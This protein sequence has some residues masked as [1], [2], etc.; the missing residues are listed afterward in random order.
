MYNLVKK[1]MCGAL[2]G[3]VIVVGTPD[4]GT[5]L[6]AH[7]WI[8]QS[9]RAE[10]GEWIKS[11]NGKWW[12][13]RSDG[14]YPK[15][16]WEKL[17]NKW[18]YFDSSGWMQTGW[19]KIN[20]QWYY[21]GDAGDGS[22]KTGWRKINNKW[23]YLGSA[24]DGA[25]KYGWQ[26]INN[27][28][29][30]LGGAEDGVMKFG[31]QNINSKWYYFGN[32]EDGA[33]KTG[34]VNDSNKFYYLEDSGI[35]AT[36][37][38]Y[39][40]G[41]W[42]YLN[43]P[44]GHMHT[45]THN[46]DGIDYAFHAVDGHMV[47]ESS[48]V[49][50]IYTK[51]YDDI[52]TN[53]DAQIISDYLRNEYSLEYHT[54][55]GKNDFV[56]KDSLINKSK[57]NRGIFFYSGH[58]TDGRLALGNGEYIYPS[59]IRKAGLNNTKIAFFF[60]C[61]AGKN[62]GGDNCVDAAV[63]AGAKAAYG[64]TVSSY[65]PGD[66]YVMKI[67]FESLMQGNTLNDAVYKAKSKRPLYNPLA[68]YLVLRGDGNVTLARKKEDE[69]T[70]VADDKISIPQG[71]DVD[72]NN[73]SVLRCVRR[74][75]GIDT[76]DV[77][78]YDKEMGEY[79]VYRDELTVEEL[80]K[81]DLEYFNASEQNLI[82]ELSKNKDYTEFHKFITKING[83]LTCILTAEKLEDDVLSIEVYNL[84]DCTDITDSINL[85]DSVW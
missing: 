46:I 20:G 75:Q 59:D 1:I 58:G 60:A 13:K 21:L 74:W 63:A 85:F 37:W 10:S 19:Q 9:V 76:S 68:K 84:A 23:Y 70:V 73:E 71:Y 34:W 33:M 27:K 53:Y 79:D 61:K 51:K 28:R 65:I 41:K 81:L 14:S 47:Y 38:K 18:Y 78:V 8:A 32:A 77:I 15:G 2:V 52:N 11:D 35:M 6:F 7:R 67:M 83:S 54:N 24:E 72:T 57:M 5:A 82:G 64:Y 39:I 25:M 50:A 45:G 43:Q 42:Y 44:S 66:R 17:N 69:T 49:A 12:Y 48:K 80:S 4:L 55:Y 16:E 36:G 56:G 62:Y 3:C 26:T 30:Y 40:K 31:W 29:Y 22:M